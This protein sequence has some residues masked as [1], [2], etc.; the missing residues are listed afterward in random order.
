MYILFLLKAVMLTLR[1]VRYYDIAKNELSKETSKI[2]LSLLQAKLLVIHFLINHSRM[3]EAWTNFGI[4]VR[5]AQALRLHR[6]AMHDGNINLIHHEY[7]KRLFWSIYIYDRQL[8][9]IFGRP[10]ALH[11]MDIDQEEFVL[12]NDDDITAASCLATQPGSFCSASAMLHYTRLASILGEILSHLHGPIGRSRGVAQLQ[13]KATGIEQSL[14]H[15]QANLPTYLDYTS[16][17]PSAM[18]VITQR[19]MCTLKLTFLFAELLLYRP[20]IVFSMRRSHGDSSIMNAWTKHSYDNSIKS[21]KAIVDE[22]RALFGQ[23][24]LSGVFGLFIHIQFAAI[25]TLYLYLLRWQHDPHVRRLADDAVT[26]LE[27]GTAGDRVSQHYLDVLK[28]LRATFEGQGDTT[29]DQMA[30]AFDDADFQGH[31]DD[32]GDPWAVLL[33]ESS[34]ATDGEFVG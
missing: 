5:Q 26:D 19:Q 28:E 1:S 24:L 34:L 17:P 15:W 14:S 30:V 22:C 31:M 27:S 21:A 9:S 11:D 4:V 7:R 20:F 8:S 16:L 32:A 25:G 10:C 6:R 33:F 3:H 29:I 2:T 23:G 12:A 18:S 13:E